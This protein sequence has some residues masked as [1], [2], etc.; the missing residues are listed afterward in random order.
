M[1]QYK[2]HPKVF[3]P[4]Y[5]P[6]YDTYKNHSFTIVRYPKEAP[7]HIE[8][9]CIDDPNIKVNGFIHFDEIVAI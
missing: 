6:Y 2:F 1:E 8:V 5:A 7:G 9:R 3:K 4:P